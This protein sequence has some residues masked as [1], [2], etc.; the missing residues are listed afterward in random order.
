MFSVIW[1]TFYK[2]NYLFLSFYL[3]S[4]RRVNVYV[5]SSFCLFLPFVCR[6]GSRGVQRLLLLPGISGYHGDGLRPETTALLGQSGL[7]LQGHHKT[8]RNWGGKIHIFES[9]VILSSL[10]LWIQDKL[11]SHRS[12]VVLVYIFISFL[13]WDIDFFHFI[14]FHKILLF[15]D[16]H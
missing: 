1:D 11:F 14:Y 2:P 5:F 15:K 10:F 16:L 3:F 4:I 13:I 9:F 7:Q 8:S 12:M 6:C